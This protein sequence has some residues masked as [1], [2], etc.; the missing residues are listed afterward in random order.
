MGKF[1]QLLSVTWKKKNGI[2]R[3]WQLGGETVCFCMWEVLERS[4]QKADCGS[5]PAS[6]M[7]PNNL[8]FWIFGLLYNSLFVC[9]G[10]S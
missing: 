4:G 2:N 9:F 6:E 10:W 1:L 8:Y 5:K 3:L 7:A